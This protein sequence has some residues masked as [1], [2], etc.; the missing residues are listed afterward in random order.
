MSG[1]L[2]GLDLRGLDLQGVEQPLQSVTL[3][4]VL[5]FATVSIFKASSNLCNPDLEANARIA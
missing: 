4:A 3:G 2:S 1:L 5:S